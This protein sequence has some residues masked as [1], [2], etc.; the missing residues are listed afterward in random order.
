MEQACRG[1]V[2]SSRNGAIAAWKG[3]LTPS[4]A[5]E[6]RN[7]TIRFVRVD[8]KVRITQPDLTP[9]RPDAGLFIAFTR[10]FLLGPVPVG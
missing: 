8:P 10:A 4:G 5:E 1:G 3:L 7:R 9:G 6:W 2:I